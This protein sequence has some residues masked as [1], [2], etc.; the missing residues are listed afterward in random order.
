MK[1]FL[2]RLVA[3]ACALAV[4]TWAFAGIHIFG[5]TLK[6]R[7]ITLMTVALLFGVVNALVRPVVAFFAFPLYLLTLGLM[8]FVVNAVMLLLTSWVAG[9]VDVGFSVDGFATA[10]AGALLISVVSWVVSQLLPDPR[11]ERR[12]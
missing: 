9:H 6:D 5:D 3:D 12:S 1:A 2:L 7:L 4:A 8:F 10:L 11:K